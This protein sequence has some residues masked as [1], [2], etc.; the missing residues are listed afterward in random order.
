MTIIGETTL[1]YLDKFP[2]LSTRNLANL[3]A[4]EQP[5]IYSTYG[6]ARD[7]VRY[8][9]SEIKRGSKDKRHAKTKE[10]VL[11]ESHKE[12][13]PIFSIPSGYKKIAVLSDVHIPY[14]D[15]EAIKTA[16]N[17]CKKEKVDAV[18]LNGD[19][20][21]M[22]RLSRFC[23]DPRNRVIDGEIDDAVDFIKLLQDELGIVYYKLG[24]HEERWQ[25]YMRSAAAELIGM[26]E[27]E[28]SYILN[29]RGADV[30]V[31]FKSIVMAGKLPILHGHEFFGGGTSSVNP[32]RGLFLKANKSCVVGHHHRTSQHTD[33]DVIGKIITT[34][35]LG[36]LCGLTPE[37]AQINKWNHGFGI[38]NV[39]PSG[40][41]D[42]ENFRIYK[43]KVYQ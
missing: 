17:H 3:L 27:F 23:K 4:K 40:E 36:C 7:S 39:A 22:Y 6:C 28:L 13:Y 19:I 11:P 43:G 12:E 35:S 18:L 14:H 42:F 2:E 25:N 41:F 31:I 29:S 38:V 37:Y 34:W 16:I 1:K 9:R 21:D 15:N 26:K 20:I 32:A 30:N 33:S 5:E 24:N 10:Y 8:Y